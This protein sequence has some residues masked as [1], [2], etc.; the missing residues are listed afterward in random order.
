MDKAAR[1]RKTPAKT[2]V[3]SGVGTGGGAF[4]KDL[5]ALARED[6]LP[7]RGVVQVLPDGTKHR[8]GIWIGNIKARRDRLD[9]A[10]RAALAELGID[11]AS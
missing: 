2:A 4:Q 7:G 9:P 5:E 11:W 8:T 10:Q 3:A 6:R 1:A